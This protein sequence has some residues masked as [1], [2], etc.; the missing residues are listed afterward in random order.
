MSII[1]LLMEITS[2][3]FVT[4]SGQ[5]SCSRPRLEAPGDPGGV[6]VGPSRCKASLE[7]VLEL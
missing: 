2:L 3:Y 6:H 5:S 4:A 7:K 1:I